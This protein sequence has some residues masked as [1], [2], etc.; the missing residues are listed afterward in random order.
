[1]DDAGSPEDL[2]PKTLAAA[3]EISV[4][5]AW[6]LLNEKR[7][8]SQGMAIRIFRATGHRL[9]PIATATHEEIAV[10]ERFQGAA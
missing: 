8:L 4:P 5:Y 9:G 7:P 6:Q 3:I 1:M 2:T 10:L